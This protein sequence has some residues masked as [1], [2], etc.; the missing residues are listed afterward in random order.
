MFTYKSHDVTAQFIFAAYARNIKIFLICRRQQQQHPLHVQHLK[1]SNQSIITTYF[2]YYCDT[3][4][5]HVSCLCTRQSGCQ[6]CRTAPNRHNGA[7]KRHV[8][9]PALYTR[10]KWLSRLREWVGV[11]HG[12]SCGPC[13]ISEPES[14]SSGPLFPVCWK[15]VR[16]SVAWSICQIMRC[17]GS[18]G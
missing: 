9:R 7:T 13:C 2:Q 12:T 3:L 14:R 18:M 5:S 15:Y 17:W 6:S 8:Q 10:H 16:I 1:N 4:Y 11:P